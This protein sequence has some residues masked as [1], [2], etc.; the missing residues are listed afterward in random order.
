MKK[1]SILKYNNIYSVLKYIEY[2]KSVGYMK[3][4]ESESK[5]K[6]NKFI[7]LKEGEENGR[8]KIHSKSN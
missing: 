5:E 1:Y 4:F 7:E 2:K 3:I 8:T 6:C